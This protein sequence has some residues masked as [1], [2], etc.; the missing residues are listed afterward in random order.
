MRCVFVCPFSYNFIQIQNLFGSTWQNLLGCFQMTAASSYL[1]SKI[2][3][4][5]LTL[6]QSWRPGTP[7]HRPKRERN[8]KKVNN[9]L[10]KNCRPDSVFWKKYNHIIFP[11]Y[12]LFQEPLV[13][14]IW[15]FPYLQTLCSAAVAVACTSGTQLT[16]GPFILFIWGQNL[17]L[18][19]LKRKERGDVVLGT[20]P[21]RNSSVWE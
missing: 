3:I 2:R 15:I 17:C 18:P 5:E 13:P 20:T 12:N 10:V 11:N 14:G 21:L 8:K 19:H 7:T 16:V 9:G 4:H 6:D 1:K